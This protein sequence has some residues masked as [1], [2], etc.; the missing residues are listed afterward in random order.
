MS[1]FLSGFFARIAASLQEPGFRV[2]LFGQALALQGTWVQGTAQRWLVLEMTDSTLLVGVLGAVSGLPI[3]LFALAGG[4]MAD[5]L[6]RISFL[7][8][9]QGI[10][11]LQALMFGVLVQTGHIEYWTI[12][13]FS[14][15]LGAGI[16]F[17]VPA[18]QALIYNLVGRDRITNGIALHS[19]AFNLARFG[20]PALAGFMI[21]AGYMAECFYFKALTSTCVIVCLVYVLHNYRRYNLP[22]RQK[23]ESPVSAI[24]EAVAFARNHPV[25]SRL[26][27]LTICFGIFLL[28]YSML[29][30]PFGRDILGLNASGYG[31]L[32]ASNGLGAL[33]G[34]IVVAGSGN[35][36][37]RMGWWWSGTL[38]FP[39]SLMVL[40]VT[41]SFWQAAVVLFLSGFAMVTVATSALSFMQKET[42]DSLRGR[43]MGLFS[44]CFMGLF[45]LGSL[46]QGLLGELIGVRM[47]LLLAGIVGIGATFMVWRSWSRRTVEPL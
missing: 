41:Q 1:F 47:T 29:L 11:A 12:L 10:I 39:A 22:V 28:P 7:I 25:L 45:P 36:K 35:V 13:L 34:A 40:S 38:F 24:L 37:N 4:V 21:Q 30:A 27:A 5:R 26:L 18:R 33:C 15:I 32:S 42:P 2:F 14:F 8:A 46:L 23:K 31:L 43:M 20:G 9:V 3:L 6:P 17:E 16:S 19:T 44:T